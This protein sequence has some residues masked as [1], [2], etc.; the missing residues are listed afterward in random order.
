MPFQ[1]RLPVGGPFQ[2]LEKKFLPVRRF[3]VGCC[4]AVTI[5]MSGTGLGHEAVLARFPASLPVTTFETETGMGS[6]YGTPYHGKRAASGQT[7]DMDKL[8]AAHRDLPFG[9]LVR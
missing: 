3:A 1:I 6:W 8:T 4:A 7:Y 5:L 2:V 9:T